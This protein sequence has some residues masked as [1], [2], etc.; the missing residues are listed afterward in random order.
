[1]ILGAFV[2]SHVQRD[3]KV[4]CSQVHLPS[5]CNSANTCKDP[6]IGQPSGC[7]LGVSAVAHLGLV[8]VSQCARRLVE[9]KL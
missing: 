4:L 3:L 2:C 5:L 1:M 8:V 6:S 7:G 9:L